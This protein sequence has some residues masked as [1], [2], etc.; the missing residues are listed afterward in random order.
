MLSSLVRWKLLV[1]LVALKQGIEDISIT[2]VVER[3]QLKHYLPV[4]TQLAPAYDQWL[5]YPLVAIRSGRAE[6]RISERC[7]LPN[8]ILSAPFMG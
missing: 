5:T 2:L 8:Q 3:L 7:N 1:V 6:I 4:R